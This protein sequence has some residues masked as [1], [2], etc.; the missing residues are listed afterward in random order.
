M[1]K[2]LSTPIAKTLSLVKDFVEPGKLNRP[3]KKLGFAYIT[4]HNTSNLNGN[5]AA[6]A[7]FVKNKGWYEHKERKKPVSWHYT[8]DDIQAYQHLPLDEIG[9]HAGTGNSK[10]L[11]VEVCMHKGINQGAANVRAALLVAGLLRDFNLDVNRI[12]PHQYWT[13]KNCPELMLS[14]SGS[15]T[16]NN[17]KNTAE[18]IFIQLDEKKFSLVEQDEYNAVIAAMTISRTLTYE[19]YEEFDLDHDLIDLSED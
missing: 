18:K 6:H 17:F 9:L 2:F 1:E 15:Q 8:V 7:R 3:G 5:A 14:N 4:I 12:V 11:G 10:S 19:E 13:K 16:F